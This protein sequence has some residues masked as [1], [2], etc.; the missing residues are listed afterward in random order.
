MSTGKEQD[1]KGPQMHSDSPEAAREEGSWEPSTLGSSASPRLAEILSSSQT[2]PPSL[3]VR[4][5]PGSNLQTHL[6]NL[7]LACA[8]CNFI[9]LCNGEKVPPGIERRKREENE[10]IKNL[11][12]PNNK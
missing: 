11:G 9:L 7:E 10:N 6:L 3:S 5:N 1:A 4:E 12:K 8:L 2:L